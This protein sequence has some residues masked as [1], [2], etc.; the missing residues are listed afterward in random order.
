MEAGEDQKVGR[1]LTVEAGQSAS[2]CWLAP[3][4]STS[5]ES[6]CGGYTDQDPGMAVLCQM[7][8]SPAEPV[9]TGSPGEQEKRQ[10]RG[11]DR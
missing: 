3:L 9:I 4:E 2:A 5:A 6:G 11:L 8:L 10:R 1:T 7:P